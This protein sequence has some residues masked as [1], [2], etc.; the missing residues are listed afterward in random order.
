M[1]LLIELGE[2]LIAIFPVVIAMALMRSKNASPT[3]WMFKIIGSTFLALLQIGLLLRRLTATCE[4]SPPLQC[5]SLALQRERIPGI[6]DFCR[7]CAESTKVQKTPIS[8]SFSVFLNQI[9]LPVHAIGAII[10][11][12]ISLFITISFIRAFR[13]TMSP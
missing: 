10:T 12:L 1:A 9:S 5:D 7:Y 13:A 6:F 4:E 3:G 2:F 8:E 11:L